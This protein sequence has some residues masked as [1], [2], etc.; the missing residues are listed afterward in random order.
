M[1]YKYVSE[2]DAWGVTFHFRPP[3]PTHL[4]D[5][6]RTIGELVT[7]RVEVDYPEYLGVST[8]SA[9]KLARVIDRSTVFIANTAHE[10]GRDPVPDIAQKLGEFL[11]VE[12]TF[13]DHRHK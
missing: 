12:V 5:N 10:A 3:V 8:V 11:E 1:L 2:L 4:K 9:E 7:A 13:T 6:P